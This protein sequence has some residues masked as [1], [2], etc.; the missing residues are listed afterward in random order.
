M[1]PRAPP[2]CWPSP[3]AQ[4]QAA[5]PHARLSRPPRGHTGSS[6][7][8]GNTPSTCSRGLHTT[9]SVYWA[10]FT[11]FPIFYGHVWLLQY[12]QYTAVFVLENTHVKGIYLMTQKRWFNNAQSIRRYILGDIY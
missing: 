12:F 9:P 10:I 4:A 6:P 2:T 8:P 7:T 11:T 5:P 3:Q 1:H